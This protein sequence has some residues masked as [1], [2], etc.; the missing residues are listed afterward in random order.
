MSSRL[1]GEMYIYITGVY[2][3]SF[4]NLSTQM[5]LQGKICQQ[6]TKRV[7]MITPKLGGEPIPSAFCHVPKYKV[8]S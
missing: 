7:V 2:V 4:L 1:S 3:F 8:F 6:K 5:S